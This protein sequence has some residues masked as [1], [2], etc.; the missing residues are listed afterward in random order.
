MY[1]NNPFETV[2]LAI[3]LRLYLLGSAKG[4]SAFLLAHLGMIKHIQISLAHFI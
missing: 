1:R 3:L 4:S 2:I